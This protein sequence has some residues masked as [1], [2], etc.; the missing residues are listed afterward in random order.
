MNARAQK[1]SKKEIRYEPGVC[2]GVRRLAG[3][4]ASERSVI[5]GRK[6]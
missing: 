5:A 4:A 6:P 2:R 1:E 3:M